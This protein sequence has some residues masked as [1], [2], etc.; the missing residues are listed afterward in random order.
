MEEL[1]NISLHSWIDR[2]PIKYEFFAKRRSGKDSALGIFE[3]SKY[4]L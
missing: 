1:I 3:M 4:I 2:L